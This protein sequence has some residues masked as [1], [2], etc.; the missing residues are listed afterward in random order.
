MPYTPDEVKQFAGSGVHNQQLGRSV[1]EDGKT[2]L[3]FAVATTRTYNA[4]NAVAVQVAALTAA[5][6]ALANAQGVNGDQIVANVKASVD[7]ALAGLTI[8]LKT[9]AP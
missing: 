5:V 1:I 2:P 4:V 6:K 7:K 8:E 3:T 9:P